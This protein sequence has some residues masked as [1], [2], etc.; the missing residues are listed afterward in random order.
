[1]IHPLIKLLATHPELLAGHLGAYAELAG[2]EVSD[3]AGSVKR[4]LVLVLSMGV[5]AALGLGLTA[6]AVMTTAVVPVAQMPAPWLLVSVP[7][8]SW[9]AAGWCWWR[10]HRSHP[11]EAFGALREQIALDAAVLSQAQQP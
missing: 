1:M 10:L 5:S 3:V 9:L 7:V 6:I 2:A 8:A 11:V 4:K